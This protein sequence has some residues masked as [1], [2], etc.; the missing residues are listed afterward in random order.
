MVV[1]T[2]DFVFACV[3]GRTC[4]GGDC[5]PGNPARLENVVQRDPAERVDEDTRVYRSGSDHGTSARIVDDGGSVVDPAAQDTNER[6][7][8]V[9]KAATVFGSRLQPRSWRK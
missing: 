3:D 8:R 2:A 4:W 5:A 6:G 7:P 9:S 1:G